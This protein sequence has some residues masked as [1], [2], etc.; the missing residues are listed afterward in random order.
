M[1]IKEINSISKLASEEK[2]VSALYQDSTVA[3]KY[4]EARFTLSWQQLL[5]ESQVQ[6]LQQSIDHWKPNNILEI[7]PGPARL[8]CELVGIRQGTLL[9]YSAE[10]INIARHRLQV[11]NHTN[12]WTIVH[13]NAFNL[14]D[15]RGPFDFIY[16]FRFIRHFDINHRKRLYNTIHKRLHPKGIFIFDVVNSIYV[17]YPH[18]S[19]TQNYDALPVFD[20]G[21]SSNQFFK[22]MQ[23]NGFKVVDLY[24]IIR[25]YRTQSWISSKLYDRTPGISRLLVKTIEAIPSR[26]PLEWIAV[27][28]KTDI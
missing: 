17:Q 3:S 18:L 1:E 4:I 19:N 27:C 12:A 22:E 13:G 5:H 14:E 20:I 9:E 11:Y 25:H 28:Q 10:M 6:Y 7:A 16:T 2:T 23:D 8:S 24:P 26:N 21:Y 15:C